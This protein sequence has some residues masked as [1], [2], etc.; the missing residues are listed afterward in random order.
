MKNLVFSSLRAGKVIVTG[1]YARRSPAWVKLRCERVRR[2]DWDMFMF[3]WN[4]KSNGV[5]HHAR[6]QRVQSITVHEVTH[7]PM[8]HGATVHT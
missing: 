1:K 6:R 5:E 3:H 4:D 2:S 7:H 8:T